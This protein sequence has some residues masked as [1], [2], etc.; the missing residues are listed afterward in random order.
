MPSVVTRV[1]EKAG[2]I[3]AVGA[4]FAVGFVTGADIWTVAL[5]PLIILDFFES[6]VYVGMFTV[7][8]AGTGVLLAYDV[9]RDGSSATSPSRIASGPTVRA[10]VPAYQD[11]DVVD[12]SV[13]SLLENDYD[14]LRISVVVEPD[15]TRTRARASE[16]AE[17][18]D[19]VDCVINDSPGSKA[20]AINTAVE[21]SS[22]D[23][24]VVFDADERASPE[25]V[26][27]AMGELVGDADVFQ[28]RRIPRPTGPVETLAYCERVVVQAGYMIGE[29]V[30]FT[31]CQSSATGFTREA[32]EAVGGYADVLTED[33]YFSHQCHKAGLTVAQNRRCTSTMEAP[34]TVRDLWG[35]RKRWRIGHVQVSHLRIVESITGGMDVDDVVSVGRAVGAVLAGATLLVLTAHVLFLLLFD[36]GSAIAALVAIYGL[37]GGVWSRDLVDGRV[38]PPSWTIALAPLVYLGHGVLTVKAM[39]EYGLTWDG[40]WYQVT[41]TGA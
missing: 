10:I 31:H 25:F 29:F 41:K 12:E 24:F 23:Y 39:F 32:F 13:T 7:A 33:I 36:P 37:I 38:G 27:I 8:I 34:H 15:D 22:A 17:R 35:Q 2:T 40:E 1:V 11:A 4:L 9:W 30:G 21:R 26:S 28:G 18:Y 3:L 16:L 6:A 19:A 14:S 5:S 20:T